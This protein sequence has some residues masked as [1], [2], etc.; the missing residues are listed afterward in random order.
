M[1]M[2]QFLRLL[3]NKN[4]QPPVDDSLVETDSATFDKSNLAAGYGPGGS[5][6]YKRPKPGPTPSENPFEKK[7]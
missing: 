7:G 1:G 6:G 3:L 5:A 4:W 2:R